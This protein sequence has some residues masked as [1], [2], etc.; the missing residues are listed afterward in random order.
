MRSLKNY[1]TILGLAIALAT[2]AAGCSS[3][4]V[5]P[6]SPVT[7]AGQT[8]PGVNGE[9]APQAA[10]AGNR[11]AENNA[12][13]IQRPR[14]ES[15]FIAG[16]EIKLYSEAD[17]KAELLLTLTSGALVREIGF[18]DDWLQLM[19]N[20]EDG[21]FVIGWAKKRYFVKGYETLEYEAMKLEAAMTRFPEE[22][23]ALIRD[24]RIK[25]GMTEQMVVLSWDKPEKKLIIQTGSERSQK[26][27]YENVHLIF[28]SG[29]LDRW[30]VY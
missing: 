24:H 22:I 2:P 4:T 21:S 17:E 23:R 15:T 30:I 18:Q 12:P 7:G 1:L 20:R 9:S 10:A 25:P 8:T 19:Y 27:V 13:I 29:R 16:E 28:K 3:A 14:Y 5:A 11:T 26:W 6:A